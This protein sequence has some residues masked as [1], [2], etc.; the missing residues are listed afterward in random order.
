MLILIFGLKE[1]VPL[2]FFLWAGFMS[3]MLHKDQKNIVIPD[4]HW[5]YVSIPML[6]KTSLILSVV[7]ETD[8]IL[9][10]NV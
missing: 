4:F 8:S 2:N 1:F 9:P 5:L 10:D 3:T 7:N 6:T